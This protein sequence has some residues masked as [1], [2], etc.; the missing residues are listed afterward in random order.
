MDGLTPTPHLKETKA[1]HSI[2][3]HIILKV[4]VSLFN[5]ART[6]TNAALFANVEAALL[7]IC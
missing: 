6:G 1:A 2:L 7:A 4:A 3:P 5:I